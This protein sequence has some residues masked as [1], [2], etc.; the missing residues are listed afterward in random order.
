[1]P[2]PWGR[3]RPPLHHLRVQDLTNTATSGKSVAHLYPS[4]EIRAYRTDPSGSPI[5][6]QLREKLQAA[7][8][9]RLP[10]NS[11]NMF[12][13]H[14]TELILTFDF[15]KTKMTWNPKRDPFSV[16]ISEKPVSSVILLESPK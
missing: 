16:Q 8:T 5:V 4:L 12:F 6:Q 2:S 13:L 10:P 14:F 15:P 1:M 7:F 11:P 9:N 3:L